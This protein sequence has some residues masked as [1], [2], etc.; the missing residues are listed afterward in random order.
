MGGGKGRG[1]LV[2]RAF[3]DCLGSIVCQGKEA[4]QQ[5]TPQLGGQ[6]P[7]VIRWRPTEPGEEQNGK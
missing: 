1:S 4:T 7:P 5:W 2:R 3:F 6:G